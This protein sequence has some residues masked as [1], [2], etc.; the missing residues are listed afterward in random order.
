MDH[1]QLPVGTRVWKEFVVDG[2]R[3]ETR[4][5]K[6]YGSG[7]D[8]YLFIA[9][10]WASDGSD[11]FPAPNGAVDANG[12]THD[13][14]A[15]WEC[16]TC[17]ANIPERVIGFSAIQLSHAGSGWTLASLVT[18]GMLSNPGASN[19]TVP[20]DATAQAAL[21]YLHAN[22]GHCHNDTVDGEQFATPYSLRLNV[23]DTTV[24]AT[25]AYQTALDQPVTEF[26]HAGITDRIAGGNTSASC[27]S[28]RMS[29][30]GSSDQ[31]PPFGTKVVDDTGSSAVNAWISTLQ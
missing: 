4:L 31:M 27:V 11:A 18:T 5:I 21:G 1:W 28:Y 6:R 29:Q 30:R 24:E 22:C 8:D 9:Y 16:D 14:P 20:G 10:Q 19:Y 7:P 12:T 2:A 15:Q 13:I 23:A 3:V 25:G 26:I 17:H